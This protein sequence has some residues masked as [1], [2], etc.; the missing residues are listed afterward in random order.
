MRAVLVGQKKGT[1]WPDNYI[2][3][4]VNMR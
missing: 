1:T 2:L 4:M 3:A